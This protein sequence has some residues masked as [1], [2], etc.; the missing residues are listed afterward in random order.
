[1]P[2]LFRHPIDRS[3]KGRLYAKLWEDIGKLMGSRNKFGM[4]FFIEIGLMR[5]I[6]SSGLYRLPDFTDFSLLLHLEI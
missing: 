6:L 1:M 4:T 3:P 2:N 5:E